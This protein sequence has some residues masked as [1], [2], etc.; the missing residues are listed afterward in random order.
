MHQQQQQQIQQQQFEK[1]T[2]Y[3]DIVPTIIKPP[4]DSSQVLDGGASE[5]EWIDE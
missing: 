4:F 5:V 1:E 2:Q 3:D